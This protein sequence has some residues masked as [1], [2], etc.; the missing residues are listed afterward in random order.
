[1]DLTRFFDHNIG[2]V[3]RLNHRPNNKTHTEY[4][5]SMR[6]MDLVRSDSSGSLA[7]RRWIGCCEFGLTCS[8]D[9][10]SQSGNQG[11]VPSGKHTKNY[12]K[13]PCFHG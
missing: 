13:S 2:G 3:K 5:C 10:W 9:P 7:R 1:M 12:G 11:H 8:S 4:G 6:S